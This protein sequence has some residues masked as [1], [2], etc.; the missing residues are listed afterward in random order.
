MIC[1]RNYTNH[2]GPLKT[3]ATEATSVSDTGALHSRIILTAFR[4]KPHSLQRKIRKQLKSGRDMHIF[5]HIPFIV[6]AIA[7]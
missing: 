6:I 4:E 7:I 3:P 1:S 2:P 5:V